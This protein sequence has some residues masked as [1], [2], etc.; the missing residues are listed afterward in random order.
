MAMSSKQKSKKSSPGGEPAAAQPSAEQ[1][2]KARGPSTLAI[3]IAILGLGALVFALVVTGDPPER[4]RRSVPV[5]SSVDQWAASPQRDVGVSERD[6]TRGP[7][8][9]PVTIVEFSDFEC[10]YCK[11]AS[12]ALGSVYERYQG[13]VRL[14]FK[15]YPLDQ[16]CNEN[17]TRPNHLY[18]CR[19]AAMA[20]CAGEQGSFWEMHDAIYGLDRFTMTALD[21]LPGEV[22]LDP[23]EFAECM[24][25]G[26]VI[27]D[28]ERD[29][30]DGQRLGVSGTPTIY[31]NGRR[32]P[33][34]GAETLATIVEHILAKGN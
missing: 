13:D 1:G 26:E 16:A 14:V 3:T 22:G 24:G 2:P 11:D 25:G 10:P 4:R 18:A 21:A 33:S 34:Q 30:A 20:R 17:M 7:D 29:I 23:D 28:I 6:F 9:A 5:A 32:A 15:N 31:V 27:A 12:V 8:D 19:A